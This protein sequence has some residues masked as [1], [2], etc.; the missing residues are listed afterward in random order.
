LIASGSPA[1]GLTWLERTAAIFQAKLGPDHH[2]L[3]AVWLNLAG[4]RIGL[5]DPA[6]D[7]VALVELERALAIHQRGKLG[8]KDIAYVRASRSDVD[9]RQGRLDEALADR[10][11]VV[12]AFRDYY[13]DK[14]S[15]VAGAELSLA[16][17]YL[18]AERIEEGRALVERALASLLAQESSPEL[19]ARAQVIAGV[20]AVAAGDA[21][22]VEL[23]EG[24][25]EPELQRW[26]DAHPDVG[27]RSDR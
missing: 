3:A 4:A 24:P 26:L 10:E 6:Q 21:E 14:H 20:C 19:L 8:A 17:S 15:I 11:L 18:L 22:R 13:G 27:P 9:I 7:A 1:E 2:K 16:L 5:N 23:G 12:A 25:L